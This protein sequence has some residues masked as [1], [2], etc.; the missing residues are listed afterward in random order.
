[1]G[2]TIQYSTQELK[3]DHSKQCPHCGAYFHAIDRIYA[4]G[5]ATHGHGILSIMTNAATRAAMEAQSKAAASSMKLLANHTRYHRCTSC[6]LYGP[7]DFA[8]AQKAY[9][10][11]R[12]QRVMLRWFLWI[13]GVPFT[14]LTI[15]LPIP[16]VIIGWWVARGLP[17]KWDV[18]DLNHPRRVAAWLADW[19]A[20]SPTLLSECN[21]TGGYADL[22]VR[23]SAWGKL[24]RLQH[25]YDFGL[26]PPATAAPPRK[27]AA[28]PPRPP[29]PSK[30]N[31]PP[32]KP[33]APPPLPQPQEDNVV[34]DGDIR[35][36]CRHC[37]Q[38]LAAD[39]NMLGTTVVCPSCEKEI[40]VCATVRDEQ[41]N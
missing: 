30:R 15:V 20:K 6:G 5:D 9:V 14:A 4:T 27:A 8:V 26:L 12:R 39:P 34:A 1:M 22:Y 3:L 2:Y 23:Q 7:D 17:R 38:H 25:K 18:Q 35:F 21:T 28:P 10:A 11:Y 36:L 24:A 37:G 40:E 41:E 13:F 19:R 29:A 16:V 32:I 31:D 33:S